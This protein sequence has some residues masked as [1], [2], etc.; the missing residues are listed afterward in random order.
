MGAGVPC[1]VLPKSQMH[2]S[3]TEKPSTE[4]KAAI[5]RHLNVPDAST[6]KPS[7]DGSNQSQSPKNAA[8]T[9]R[10]A[11]VVRQFAP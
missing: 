9:A 2:R 11:T 1:P 7:H 8:P 6:A 10:E 5:Q 3:A 4:G